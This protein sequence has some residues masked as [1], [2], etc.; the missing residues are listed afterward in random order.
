MQ[1]SVE[2]TIRTVLPKLNQFS[3]RQAPF[4]IAKALTS[5]AKAVQDELTKQLP[6]AFDRPNAF[7]RRAFAY[8]PAR[9]DGLTAWV[10]AKDKQAKYLKFGVQGGG[11]RVK[12]F[13]RR[14]GAD[15]NAD[16]IAG[17]QKLVPTRNV[18]LDQYGGVSLATIK[19]ITQQKNSTGKYGRYFIG[20]PKGG[21]KNAGLSPGIY[22][23][24]GN[25]KRIR[26]LMVFVEPK[27]YRKRLDMQGIG[28]R[29]VRATFEDELRRAWAYA[30][31]TAR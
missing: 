26:A 11:R 16:E 20:Q 4:T 23:R 7:T 8:T 30:L 25:N 6:N 28:G 22:E 3:S 12:A 10:F 5:T 2:S 17:T 27:A 21:G 9:K 19:R 31:R 13:E 15:T 14:T 24:Y 1:I 29:V 18:K